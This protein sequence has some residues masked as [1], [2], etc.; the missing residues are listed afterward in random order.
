MSV[1]GVLS[2]GVSWGDV[3]SIIGLGIAIWLIVRTGRIAR[4]TR[5]AVE[6]ATQHI[7][8]YNILLIVPELS[9]IEFELERAAQEDS[10]DHV[11]RLLREWR[12]VAS[13]FRG[14]LIRE[15]GSSV[16]LDKLVQES[17]VL[18]VTAKSQILSGK[19]AT[20]LRST[21]RAR[22]AIEGSCP[23]RARQECRSV[24]KPSAPAAVPT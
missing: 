2:S 16:N 14:L 9:R 23:V 7:G 11:H 15:E 5:T 17:L 21:Q 19:D 12:E 1:G 22:E 18:V 4:A 8:L 10:K 6:D 13:D 24:H 20:A 3:A